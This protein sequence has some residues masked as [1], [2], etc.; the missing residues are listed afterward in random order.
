[1]G[2]RMFPGFL[3][4]EV[5]FVHSLAEL[6]ALLWRYPLTDSVLDGHSQ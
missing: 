5:H 2:R 3:P 1:M 4:G 6:D